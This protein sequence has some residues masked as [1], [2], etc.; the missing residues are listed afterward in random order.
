MLTWLFVFYKNLYEEFNKIKRKN[1]KLK[2][3]LSLGGASAGVEKFRRL[4]KNEDER[5][6]KLGIN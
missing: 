6:V 2:T 1:A 5:S 4:V 3:L